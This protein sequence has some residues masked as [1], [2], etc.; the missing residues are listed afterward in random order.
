MLVHTAGVHFRF[1]TS[2]DSFHVV[3]LPKTKNAPAQISKGTIS[4][5]ISLDVAR[6]LRLPV[7]CVRLRSRPMRGATVPETTVDEDRDMRLCE[8]D[9]CAYPQRRG[10]AEVD[11]VAPATR[12]K[13]TAHCQL[14]PRIASS[15]RAHRETRVLVGCPTLSHSPDDM[16]ANQDRCSKTLSLVIAPYACG[17][18]RACT[19]VG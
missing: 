18:S 2:D 4:L 11:P 6:Q 1:D 14:G 13:P 5:P 19:S 15:I 16:T 7:V 9:V 10:Q 12:M 8:D 3:V 17:T